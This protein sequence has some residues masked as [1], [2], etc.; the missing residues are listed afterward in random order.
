MPSQD[1]MQFVIRA[2]KTVL[3]YMAVGGLLV[4]SIGLLI[5]LGTAVFGG[6][7]TPETASVAAITWNYAKLG[8]AGGGIIGLLYGLLA[9][10][11]YS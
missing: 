1:W 10:G 11:S 2:A 4:G 6:T 5:A 7:G 3:S 9:Q 8:I